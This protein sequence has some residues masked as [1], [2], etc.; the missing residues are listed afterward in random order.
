MSSPPRNATRHRRD[1]GT[2]DTHTRHRTQ[3]RGTHHRQSRARN[4]RVKYSSVSEL[5]PFNPCR[6]HS[7]LLISALQSPITGVHPG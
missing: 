2:H 5:N 4:R 6:G 3:P 1:R 7:A